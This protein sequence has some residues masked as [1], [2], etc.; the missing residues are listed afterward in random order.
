MRE[1][2]ALTPFL[3]DVR[4]QGETP[5]RL[6]TA[7]ARGIFPLISFFLYSRSPPVPAF[8]DFPFPVSEAKDRPRL[9][10]GVS[11]RYPPCLLHPA[12]S[13]HLARYRLRPSSFPRGKHPPRQ[14][15][16]SHPAGLGAPPCGTLW[17]VRNR[18]PCVRFARFPL[19]Q[20]ARNAPRVSL[21]EEKARFLA[22]LASSLSASP[23]PRRT[24]QAARGFLPHL[25]AVP[26][27]E[28]I[29]IR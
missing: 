3:N 9:N 19:F 24:T 28:S 5:P 8:G 2:Y 1:G 27:L 22:P 17:S 29:V 11:Y 20:G 13:Q 10:G 16:R 26:A 15:G 18:F 25:P 7:T 21:K 6:R 23:R 14:F 4:N 12:P